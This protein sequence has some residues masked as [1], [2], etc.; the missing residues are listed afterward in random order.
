MK[1]VDHRLCKDDGTPYP[2]VPSP[3]F[4]EGLQPEYLVMHY[5]AGTSAEGAV[6]WL[7][8]P[9]SQASAHLVIGRDAKITQLV[10]FDKIAWHAGR[11][12]WEGRT[13]LN[14]YSIGIELDNAGRLAR[15]GDRWRAWLG[16]EYEDGQVIEAVHKSDTEPGGWHIYTPQ[17]IQVAFQVASILVAEYDL[18]D[19]IGHEDIAPLRKTDPGPAFPMQSFRAALLGRRA[20][21]DVQYETIAVLNIRTGPGTQHPTIEGSPLPIGTRLEILRRQGVWALVDVL[22][23]VNDVMDMEGWVHTRYITRAGEEPL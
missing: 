20:D 16:A 6:S 15:H 23:V 8:N 9:A 18:L 17:Q 12:F 10:P 21:V 2:F 5:T 11:S 4:D 1:I 13:G 7:T 22:G 14:R 3:N 19:V